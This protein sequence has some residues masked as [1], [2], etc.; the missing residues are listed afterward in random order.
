MGGKF[1]PK[2]L[3]SHLVF[4]KFFLFFPATEWTKSIIGPFQNWVINIVARGIFHFKYVTACICA[5]M[6][7]LMFVVRGQICHH[8]TPLE[9][10]DTLGSFGLKVCLK[11]NLLVC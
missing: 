3:T 11:Y 8:P 1:A 2:K 10:G 9:S 4:F 6:R 5:N 7:P